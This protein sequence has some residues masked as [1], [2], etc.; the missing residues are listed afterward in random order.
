MVER[1]FKFSNYVFVLINEND[2]FYLYY[3]TNL[4]ILKIDNLK[5]SSMINCAGTIENHINDSY[6]LISDKDKFNEYILD[7]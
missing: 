6:K 5:K 7:D 1:I 2:G 3:P 4:L